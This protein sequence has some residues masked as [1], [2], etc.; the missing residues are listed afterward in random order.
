MGVEKI[1]FIN[2][3][4]YPDYSATSQILSDLAFDFAKS[5]EVIEVI[6]SRLLYDESA[7]QLPPFEIIQGVRINRVR[8]SHFGKENILGRLV[9][10]ATFY[11]SAGWMLFKITTVNSIVV[12]KTDPP[13]FSIVASVIVRYR[14]ARLV[15]WL[16]DIFPEVASA[17]GLSMM[18]WPIYPLLKILRNLS[19]KKASVNIVIGRLMREKLLSDGVPDEKIRIIPN[20][21]DGKMVRPVPSSK[22]ILREEWGMQGKFV[23]GYSGNLGRAHEFD[24]I[25]KA[26]EKLQYRDDIVFLFI[27]GGVQRVLLENEVFSR[28]LRNVI[29]KPYQA[30][31]VLSESLSVSDLHLVSLNPALESLI[32]PSKFFG[33][34]AVARPTIFIGDCDGEIATI[35]EEFSCGYSVE[36]GN[37][38][39]LSDKILGFV[40]APDSAISQG[41]NARNAFELHFDKVVAFESF[42][43]GFDS[44]RAFRES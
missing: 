44:V 12:V 42:K 32:V 30:R 43:S 10:Y 18:R 2:R 9:D 35:L 19:L 1:I 36:S 17:L 39:K 4:F 11:F 24:T 8:T 21:A 33:I 16:Q 25:L 29:F 15:N 38:I 20:W 23:V 34:A 14:R 37:H 26:I 28:R 41:L 6:C 40:N 31:E 13:L 27:G 3:F 5:G 7:V 22:N